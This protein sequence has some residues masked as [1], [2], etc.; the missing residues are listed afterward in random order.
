MFVVEEMKC[1]LLLGLELAICVPSGSGRK[2]AESGRTW[3]GRRAAAPSASRG[4]SS[5]TRFSRAG[6]WR[7]SVIHAPLAA[8]AVNL[9]KCTFFFHFRNA[10]TSWLSSRSIQLKGNQLMYIVSEFFF[11]RF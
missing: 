10:N 9:N 1:I 6:R 5:T 2:I 4:T 7:G 3:G 8:R 11:L